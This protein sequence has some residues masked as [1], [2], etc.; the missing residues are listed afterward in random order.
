MGR[1]LASLREAPDPTKGGGPEQ[2]VERIERKMSFSE[3]QSLAYEVEMMERSVNQNLRGEK[4]DPK[5][6]KQLYYKKML[7]AKDDELTYS[8][9][10]K[11]LAEKELKEIES[12]I[13]PKMP[14]KNEMWPKNDISLK[15][16]ALRH[17][18]AFEAEFDNFKPN[19]PATGGMVKRWQELKRRLEPDN[20]N[21]HN[22]DSIRPD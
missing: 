17:Q 7:L 5:V 19:A 15:A 13:V 8:G 14:S 11:E 10:S 3:R 4:D 9:N 1:Q 12:V 6:L 21:A 18:Q 16:Q 22:L 20:P 2:K